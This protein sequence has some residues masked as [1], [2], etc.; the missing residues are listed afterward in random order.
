M[1]NDDIPGILRA[2]KTI[3]VVGVSNKPDRDSHMVAMVLRNAGYTVIPVNPAL[4]TWE[5]VEVYDSVSAIPFPVDIV[6]IFRRPEFVPAIV[7]DAIAAQAKC[8]WMQFGTVHPEAA[9][10]A[11]DAGLAVV[12]DRCI[13]VEL[14]RMERNEE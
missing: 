14:G 6:D 5:G 13:K 9:Q 12:A 10:K 2:A 8:V 11:L 7:D 1:I 4:K 3:A